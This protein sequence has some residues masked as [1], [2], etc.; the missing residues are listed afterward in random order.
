MMICA[1]VEEHLLES[2]DE[3]LP[4]AIRQAVD[5]HLG[6]CGHCA[7]FSA[8][9]RALDLQLA[10]AIPPV[11]APPSIAAGVVARQR[12]EKREALAGSLPDIIHLTGCA[13]ATL[14]SALL[15]PVE[16]PVTLAAGAA[17]TCFTYVAMAIV[18][19]SLEAVEQPDW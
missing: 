8:T 1:D 18:R 5:L 10:A 15:L 3:P 14:L 19:S 16:A 9:M 17:F 2:I 6:S 13:V 12:R 4:A 11:A 7:A